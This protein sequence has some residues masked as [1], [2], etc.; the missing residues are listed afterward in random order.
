MNLENAQTEKKMNSSLTV[1]EP[2]QIKYQGNKYN[3]IQ[4]E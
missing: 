2:M 3:H 1:P 4:Q